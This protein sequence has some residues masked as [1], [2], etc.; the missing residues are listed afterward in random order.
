EFDA[1]VPDEAEIR[2]RNASVDGCLAAIERCPK[3]VIA[4][5]YGYAMGGGCSLALACDL[6][7]AAESAKFGIPAARLGIVYGPLE[8]AHLTSVV[9]P[10]NAARVLFTGAAFDA[11]T[12][13]AMGLA[14]AVYPDDRLEEETYKL[15]GQI[16]QNAPFSIAGAKQIIRAFVEDPSFARHPEVQDLNVQCFLTEDHREGARAFM[17][18]RAPVFRGR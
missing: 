14:T 16:A 6:R 13:Y 1:S 3:A 5:I 11:S 18:K 7:I 2:R 4:M 10:S 9:G 15:A 12:A 8:V 17:E